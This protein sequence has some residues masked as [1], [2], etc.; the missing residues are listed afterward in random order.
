MRSHAD[1]LMLLALRPSGE[2]MG[3]WGQRPASPLSHSPEESHSLDVISQELQPRTSEAGPSSIL[4]EEREGIRKPEFHGPS[5][6]CRAPHQRLTAKDSCMSLSWGNK[7]LAGFLPL[8]LRG[9]NKT[10]D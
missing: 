5:E 7:L 4:Q 1:Q 10:A 2:E 6:V 9:C 3:C 8:V